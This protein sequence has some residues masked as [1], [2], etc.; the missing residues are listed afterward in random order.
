MEEKLGKQ[1]VE[2]EALNRKIAALKEKLEKVDQ[3]GRNV[4]TID[5]AENLEVNIRRD[6]TLEMLE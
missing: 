5:E 6:K 2:L 3:E 4:N 1:E